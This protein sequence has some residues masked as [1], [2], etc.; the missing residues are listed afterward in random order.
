MIKKKLSKLKIE[1]NFLNLIRTSTKNLQRALVNGEKLEVFPL[2]SGTRQCSLLSVF[3][4][5]ILEVLANA[6][7]K[8]KKRK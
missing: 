3:L 5:I 1:D 7:R 6:I 4:N 8:K 2:R